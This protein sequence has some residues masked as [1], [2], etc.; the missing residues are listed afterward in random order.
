MPLFSP[1]SLS[2]KGV[3]SRKK[4]DDDRFLPKVVLLLCVVV[5]EM[6]GFSSP[7]YVVVV[8]DTK[9]KNTTFTRGLDPEKREEGGN[10]IGFLQSNDEEST[11]TTPLL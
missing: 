9:K 1:L 5:F 2:K 7:F 10:P 11:L 6:G 3:V 8:A 4:G